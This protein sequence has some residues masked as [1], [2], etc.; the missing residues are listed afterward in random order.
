MIRAGKEKRFA[1]KK[2]NKSKRRT[3]PVKKPE[4]KQGQYQVK[5]PRKQLEQAVKWRDEECLQRKPEL[6]RDEAEEGMK[7][8][9]K[10]LNKN[11]K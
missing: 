2:S 6:K 5:E 9:N 11:L 8:E 10:C 1:R 4:H 7:G 3:M